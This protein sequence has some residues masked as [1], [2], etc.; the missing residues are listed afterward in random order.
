MPFLK[1]TI[2]A[3]VLRLSEITKDCLRQKRMSRV[4]KCLVVAENLLT[5]GN[6]NVKNAVSNIFLFSVST[7]IEINHQFKVAQLLPEQLYNEYKKQI[8]TSGI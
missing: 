4:T 8:N 5:T 3:N 1:N 2:E 6:S 7:F